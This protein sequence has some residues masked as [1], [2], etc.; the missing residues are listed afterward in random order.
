MAHALCMWTEMA[1][2]GSQQGLPP[3]SS[4]RAATMV[5]TTPGPTEPTPRWPKRTASEYQGMV[6]WNYSA[7]RSSHS[8]PLASVGRGCHNDLQNTFGDHSCIVLINNIWLLLRWPI[9][10]N[11]LFKWLQNHTLVLSSKNISFF[12]P[13]WIGWE[14]S[15]LL[16]FASLWLTIPSLSHFCLFSFYYMQLWEAKPYLKHFT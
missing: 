13:I 11:L 4:R 8:W 14:V 3:T 2:C 9:H 6:P 15:R 10:T 5:H 1:P 12:F 7:P 16:S